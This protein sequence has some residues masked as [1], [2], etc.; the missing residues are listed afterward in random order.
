MTVFGGE[1][2]PGA[3]R[4]VGETGVDR[5]AEGDSGVVTD[6]EVPQALTPSR[7]SVTPATAV[8]LGR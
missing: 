1:P 7:H 5:V 2:T 6:A 3:A 8:R 4:G